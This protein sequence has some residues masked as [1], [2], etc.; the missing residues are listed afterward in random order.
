MSKE[1][2]EDDRPASPPSPNQ[3]ERTPI[4]RMV[5]FV[6]RHPKTSLVVGAGVSLLAGAEILAVALV[7]GAATL[8]LGRFRK[9]RNK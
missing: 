9:N 2:S 7:G 3:A 8:A 1:V 4:G 5:D 6:G